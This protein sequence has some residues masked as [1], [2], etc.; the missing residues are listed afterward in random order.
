[1]RRRVQA[2]LVAVLSG[3]TAKWR[4]RALMPG[5][6]V[7]KISSE[8]RQIPPAWRNPGDENGDRNPRFCQ[9]SHRG[10]A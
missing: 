9:I 8:R 7:S 3:A 1:M 6:D 2:K 10:G 5:I 4:R